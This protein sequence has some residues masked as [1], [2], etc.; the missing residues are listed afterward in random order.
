MKV[1]QKILLNAFDYYSTTIGVSF[2]LI[3][4]FI[5]FTFSKKDAEKLKEQYS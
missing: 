2:A 4:F 3:S 5:P 1:C